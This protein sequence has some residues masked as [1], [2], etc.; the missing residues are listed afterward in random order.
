MIIGKKTGA[1]SQNTGSRGQGSGYS[2]YN[3]ELMSTTRSQ[4]LEP[5]IT[6]DSLRSAVH[7]Q[8]STI[9]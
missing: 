6:V 2:E 4:E 5:R 1:K 8:W 7:S 9:N 3:Y